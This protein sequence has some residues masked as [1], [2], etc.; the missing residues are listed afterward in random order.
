MVVRQHG[1]EVVAASS[2]PIAIRII[3][4]IVLGAAIQ[5]CIINIAIVHLLAQ[6]GKLRFEIG[7][8]LALWLYQECAEP[9]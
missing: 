8:A 9:F 4:T 3:R 1:S 7:E 5:R 6:N 2:A